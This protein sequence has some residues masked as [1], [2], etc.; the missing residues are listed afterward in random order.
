MGGVVG[1]G[2]PVCCAAALDAMMSA[3][4]ATAQKSELF[5]LEV[6]SNYGEVTR[7]KRQGVRQVQVILT[8]EHARA[9]PRI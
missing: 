5:M 3:A 2:W 7:E 9:R 1:I 4:S 8:G 6:P